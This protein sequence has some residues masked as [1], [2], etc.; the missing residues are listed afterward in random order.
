MTSAVRG[1]P[2]PKQAA[3]ASSSRSLRKDPS[4]V[5]RF[6]RSH[7]SGRLRRSPLCNDLPV[8][9]IH[10]FRG[11]AGMVEMKMGEHDPAQVARA[12]ANGLD[13]LNDGFA[14]AGDAGVDDGHLLV[15]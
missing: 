6:L 4:S 10:E 11:T 2:W 5:R 9:E 14:V 12:A 1:G 13:V 8:S 3:S 7:I 15:G